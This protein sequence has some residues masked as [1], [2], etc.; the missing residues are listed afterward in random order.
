MKRRVAIWASAGF[1]VAGCW[2]VYAFV[3]SP[4]S[5]LMI[6]REPVVRATLYLSCPI[7]YAGRYYPIGLG[8]VLVVNAATYAA[9]GMIVEAFRLRPKP[10]LVA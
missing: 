1:L 5:F 6:L 3:T 8:W 4:D 9:I 7:S 2:A 10:S